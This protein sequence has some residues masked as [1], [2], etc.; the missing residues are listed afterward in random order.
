MKINTNFVF[1]ILPVRKNTKSKDHYMQHLLFKLTIFL[2]FRTL[3]FTP[4]RGM[5]AEMYIRA[6]KSIRFCVPSINSRCKLSKM[7]SWIMN[8]LSFIQRGAFHPR[9]HISQPL[10]YIIHKERVSDK[11][12]CQFYVRHPQ[13]S[14]E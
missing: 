10:L 9:F 7:H 11:R 14:R 4:Y 1:A 5:Y 8:D 3:Y 6:N 12:K 2:P 13:K